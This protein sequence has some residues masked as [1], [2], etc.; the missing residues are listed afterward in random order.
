MTDIEL[1]AS[2]KIDGLTVEINMNGK[3]ITA[4]YTAGNTDWV[5][6]MVEVILAMN[7]ANVTI[8]GNGTM[9]AEGSGKHIEVISAIDGAKVTIEN[10]TFISGGCTAIYA[11]RGAVV[12]IHGGHFDAKAAYEGRYFTL[13]INEGETSELGLGQ[14]IVYGGKFVNFDPAN[15][16]TDGKDHGNK[17]PAGYHSIKCENNVYSVGKH[18]YENGKCECGIDMTKFDSASITLQ[19]NLLVNFKVSVAKLNEYNLNV[20]YAII[21]GV[22]VEGKLVE[23]DNGRMYV[24]S[25]AVAPHK[26]GDV[27][28]AYLVFSEGENVWN[29]TPVTYSVATY[30]YNKLNDSTTTSD[31]RKLLVSIL[32][33]G[34]AAQ[35]AAN[36]NVENL[37]NS[38][39]NSGLNAD[40]QKVEYARPDASSNQTE[41]EGATVQW[42]AAGLL[43]QDKIVI[44]FAFVTAEN[45]ED[46]RVRVEI[47]GQET[48]YVSSFVGNE[49]GYYVYI[50]GLNATQLYDN[51]T[52]TVIKGE[53]EV[54]SSSLTYS[55]AVYAN[56]VLAYDGV[57]GYEKL[58]GLVKYLMVYGDAAKA[59]IGK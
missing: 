10:G 31:F 45:I 47:E 5:D 15:H 1:G 23:S 51:V 36:H 8:T 29:G 20:V 16:T 53:E 12:T 3:T 43:L 54:V 32:N 38:F 17:V 14:I 9:K 24:F 22:Q 57:E 46:L 56:K 27:L 44:R 59:Y 49:N 28:D 40:E 6:D 50:E 35:V 19:D 39:D 2:I 18:S 11:T 25:F 55:V 41:F 13:D 42:T 52:V 4:S 58:V 30:C 26:M 48:Y 33:Y 37:V 7:G 21:E 34:A